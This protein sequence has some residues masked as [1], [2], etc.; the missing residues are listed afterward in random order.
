MT[1]RFTG[2]L[3][4]ANV[5]VKSRSQIDSKRDSRLS[6]RTRLPDCV[7]GPGECAKLTSE[8][9]A[10]GSR[11]VYVLPNLTQGEMRVWDLREWVAR[12]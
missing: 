10:L 11:E 7:H 3:L 2:R 6:P 1:R 8:L 5:N 12:V 9:R 4:V